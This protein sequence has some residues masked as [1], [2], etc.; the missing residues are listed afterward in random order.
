MSMIPPTATLRS[1]PPPSLEKTTFA[2]PKT[3][4][5]AC[6]VLATARALGTRTA[7]LAG[8][9]DWIVD[10]HLAPVDKAE[11]ID[12]VVDLTG[13]EA[14]SRIALRE[15]GGE[16]WMSL[17]GGVTYWALRRDARVVGTIPMLSVMAQDVGAV[18]IQTRGTLA[19]NIAT[20]SPAADGVPAL[21]ALGGVVVLASTRGERRVALEEFF[22]GYRR[23]VLA[24]DELIVA[25]DVRIPRPGAIV[26]WRKV[27]TRLAQAISKVALAAAIEVDGQGIVTR[28]RFGMASVGPVTEPLAVLRRQLEGARLRSI[29]RAL[30]DA[31]V[32]A[33]V[34]P[35]DD[36]RSTADYRLHVAK[37]LV[38]RALHAEPTV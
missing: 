33:C 14:L 6:K 20:A 23:T 37:A 30:S 1:Y 7:L 32:A 26:S 12:L 17:G 31:A 22:T 21:M 19:G 38:W 2:S 27:G 3:V 25:V 18:Q 15:E 13:V 34:R 28:A 5:E 4:E 24:E 10:R 36:V 9:T 16:R 29:D 35:I 11:P 8:G